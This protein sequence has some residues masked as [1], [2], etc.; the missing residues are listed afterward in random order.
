M[1]THSSEP[2]SQ[3]DSARKSKC[4]NQDFAPTDDPDFRF[5]EQK[6]EGHKRTKAKIQVNNFLKDEEKFGSD[7]DEIE[8]LDNFNFNPNVVNMVNLMPELLQ[9]DCEKKI[10]CDYDDFDINDVNDVSASIT[11]ES[12]TVDDKS[13]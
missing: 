12:F 2:N 4:Y 6:R 5:E 10:I 7:A 3:E 8:Y 11:E 1:L 9:N 13:K